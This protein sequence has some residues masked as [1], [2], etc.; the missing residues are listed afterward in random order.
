LQQ[1]FAA[2]EQEASQTI[3]TSLAS[4]LDPAIPSSSNL[5]ALRLQDTPSQASA[6]RSFVAKLQIHTSTS[7]QED[8]GLLPS[9]RRHVEQLLTAVERMIIDYLCRPVADCL[10]SAHETA[11]SSGGCPS[12][13]ENPTD[14]GDSLPSFTLQPSEHVTVVG[15]Y[16]LS[17]VQELEPVVFGASG[18]EQKISSNFRDVA[19]WLERVCQ[20]VSDLF[21]DRVRKITKYSSS[22]ASQIGVDLD[23][24]GKVFA[25]MHNVV[26]Q[27]VPNQIVYSYG[28][29]TNSPAR[30]NNQTVDSVG[31]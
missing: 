27:S 20:S 4:I 16:L 23:Y 22:S 24:I 31:D 12:G 3:A 10:A 11:W 17:L 21:L 7:I 8:V 13:S 26:I 5:F 14:M 2:F 6:L 25:G 28:V 19:F 9:A 29:F 18:S 15:E 1:D 30:S